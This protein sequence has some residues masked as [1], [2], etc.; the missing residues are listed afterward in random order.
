MDESVN[1]IGS[2][3]IHHLQNHETSCIGLKSTSSG[4]TLLDIGMEDPFV[5]AHQRQSRF[6][7]KIFHADNTWAQLLAQSAIKTKP[8]F[9]W[10]LKAMSWFAEIAHLD[11]AT[12]ESY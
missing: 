11:L 1:S 8:S 3:I 10:M 7:W 9:S 12:M 2:S 6:V 5:S 4:L